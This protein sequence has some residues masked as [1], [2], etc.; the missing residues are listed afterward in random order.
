MG[1]GLSHC[2]VTSGSTSSQRTFWI[3]HPAP[4][5]GCCLGQAPRRSRHQKRRGKKP[6]QPVESAKESHQADLADL[7]SLEH[8][9]RLDCQESL[10][11][12]AGQTGEQGAIERR[13]ASTRSIVWRLP[14]FQLPLA[15]QSAQPDLPGFP[16]SPGAPGAPGSPDLPDLPDGFL[17]PTPLAASASFLFFFGGGSSEVLGPGSNRLPEPDDRSR[18]FFGWMLIHSSPGSATSHRPFSESQL[19]RNPEAPFRSVRLTRPSQKTF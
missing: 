9:E 17:L 15:L 7:E 12:L 10:A 18:R 14:S 8:L 11:D 1:D 3:G 6:R 2:L 5:S 4:A 19:L 13:A 16:G